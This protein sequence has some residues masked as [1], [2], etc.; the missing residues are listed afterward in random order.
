MRRKMCI[1]LCRGR[2]AP[3][4]LAVPQPAANAADNGSKAAAEPKQPRKRRK[5]EADQ[6]SAEQDIRKE[7]KKVHEKAKGKKANKV[8][9]AGEEGVVVHRKAE[10]VVE[11]PEEAPKKMK[12]NAAKGK[13]GK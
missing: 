9:A 4:S 2:K 8:K 7:P 5:E 11:F 1:L 13:K 6:Q 12:K 3:A 10:T